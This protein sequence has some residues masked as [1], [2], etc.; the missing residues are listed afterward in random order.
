MEKAIVSFSFD[1]G[2]IDNYTIAYPI[3]KKYR[4][5]AT[6][7]ITTGYVEGKIVVESLTHAY[8]MTIGMVKELYSDPEYEIAG[9]G[10]WHKNT[11]NDILDGVEKLRE[12]LELESLGEQIGFASPGTSL[13]LKYYQ[14]IKNELRNH[15]I[16]Y[17]RLSKRYLSS[18]RL[19]VLCRKAA[20]IFH[21]PFLFRYAYQDTLVNE[22]KDNLLYSVPILAST[23]ICEI[24][25]LIHKAIKE[26]KACVLMWHSI[27]PSDEIIDNFDYDVRKFEEL[28]RWLKDMHEQGGLTLC[29]MMDLY[30]QLR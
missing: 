3:L 5:P 2:R 29:K 1:D 25:A 16:C 21:W 4:I 22:I 10:Y 6:F 30:N 20:R 17:V 7:N 15:G 23:T 18:P 24:K 14:T 9:H 28:C 11:L 12:D 27:V 26:K 13:D 19:K 8:P